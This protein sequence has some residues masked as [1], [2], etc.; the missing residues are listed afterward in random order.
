MDILKIKIKNKKV[1]KVKNKTESQYKLVE[2]RHLELFH[3]CWLKY[4]D[5]MNINSGGFLIKI[6]LGIAFLKIP[7]TNETITLE[8]KDHL[9]YVDSSV[10]NYNSMVYFISMENKLKKLIHRY[11][12]FIKINNL[13]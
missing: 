8:I 12:H 3:N 9:F 2:E 5:G 1:K 13:D 11:N 4:T 7:R 10:P 6:D